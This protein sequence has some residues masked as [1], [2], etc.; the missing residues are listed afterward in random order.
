MKKIYYRYIILLALLCGSTLFAQ[1]VDDAFLNSQT[2]YEGTSR[3]MAMGNATGALGGDIT[4]TCINPAGMGLYR[5]KE[6]TF[7]TGFQHTL[8]QSDYYGT[9]TNDSK[10][11]MTIPSIGLVFAPQFSNYEAVRYIQFGIGFTRTNDF[12]FSSTAQGLNPSSSMV[13]AF[14]QTVSGIDELFRP[15]TSP[16]NVGDYLNNNYPYDLSP[17]WETFLFDQYVD[18]LGH[19]YYDS[20]VPPGNVYQQ[21]SITS[22]GRTEEWTFALSANLYDKFFVGASFGL[23]HLKRISKRQ[24]SEIPANEQDPN[25]LFTSWDYIEELGDT[26]WGANCK[27]GIICYPAS[28]LRVGV[29][30]HSRTRYTFGETWATEISTTLNDTPDGERYHRHLSPLF[31]QAYEFRTPNT[32][33]GSLAF[34][35]GQHGL[36]S[37]D[38]EYMNYGSSRFTSYEYS[39]SDVNSNIKDILKPTF[40][41]RL[42][43]EWRVRQFFLRGGVAYYGSPYGFGEDYGSVKKIACGFGYAAGRIASWDFAYEL[44]ECTTGYTPYSCYDGDENIAGEV[45]QHRWRNKLMVTLKIKIE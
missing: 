21:N 35:I 31:Y 6:F 20:P 7:T 14:L 5:S 10:T 13:D 27:V 37:T 19:I 17:A 26:A 23:S 18:T 42:G 25:N 22:K 43:T 15:G 39:F 4:A 38:V 30:W 11:R 29:A 1:S 2:Y 41:I 9:K 12:N 45:V 24:Y 33:I 16:T 40:N 44:T 8:I 36:I 32:F 3:S 34:I 28:W